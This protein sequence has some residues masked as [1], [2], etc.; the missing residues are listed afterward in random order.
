MRIGHG[1][2][3]KVL[4]LAIAAWLIVVGT[5][6]GSSQYVGSNGSAKSASPHKKQAAAI[7]KPYTFPDGGR[8]LFPQYRLV[9]LYGTPDMPALGALGQQPLASTLTRV[10]KLAKNYQPYSK[11]PILPTLE[12][13]ATVASA[14]PT[15]NNDYSQEV[16]S[17]MLQPWITAARTHGDY[18]VLDLQPGRQHFLP[19]A[20]EYAA[21]LKQPNVGSANIQDVNQTATWLAALTKKYQLPQKLFLLQQFR[22]TMLPGRS[23]LN[24]TYPQLAYAIQMDGQG[25]QGQ[26]LGTWHAIQEQPPPNVH[27]GWKN[28]YQKDTPL[29]SPAATMALAPTPW[30]VS[31][32]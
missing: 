7:P 23:K 24:T 15:K 19:Q 11:Q 2:M 18:V 5:V 28:F 26:K 9:A 25:N 3:V 16:S 14:T 30:Y 1:H 21:L 31:N 22:L 20:E 27:F 13:I 32:Q 17:G 12:I 6:A 29:R 4:L 8:T 10:Q